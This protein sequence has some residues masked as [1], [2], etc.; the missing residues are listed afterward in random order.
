MAFGAW[1]RLGLTRSKSRETVSMSS[2]PTTPLPLEDLPGSLATRCA[3]PETAPAAIH[4]QQTNMAARDIWFEDA[5]RSLLPAGSARTSLAKRGQCTRTRHVWTVRTGRVRWAL[6]TV[7]HLLC[8]GPGDQSSDHVPNIDRTPPSSLRVAVI[9]PHSDSFLR[10]PHIWKNE[11]RMR[12]FSR[13]GRMCSM[14]MPDGPA[15]DPLSANRRCFPNLS[16]SRP[17]GVRHG[18][19]EVI[20]WMDLRTWTTF[21]SDPGSNFCTLQCLSGREELTQMHQ[22]VRSGST[23]LQVIL[24]FFPAFGPSQRRRR[25]GNSM[26]TNTTT[27]P[28]ERG[29]TRMNLSFEINLL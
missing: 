25:I 24:G 10:Q 8:D 18:A 15:A 4:V 26:P 3:A 22:H 19:S 1:H 12:G 29:L 21:A 6:S 13:R 20:C 2:T 14:V 9:R 17:I 23:S 5:G 7:P 11:C 16:S 27:L 28:C